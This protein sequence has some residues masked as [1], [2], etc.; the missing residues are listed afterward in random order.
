MGKGRKGEER[1]AS[2]T[3][4]DERREKRGRRWGEGETERKKR[5]M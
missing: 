1:L 3:R 4:R 2:G 5:E